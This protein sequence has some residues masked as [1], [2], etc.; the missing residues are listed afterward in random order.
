VPIDTAKLRASQY[1]LRMTLEAAGG[2][3][4]ERVLPFEVVER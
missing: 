4:V 1:L 2:E 3:R